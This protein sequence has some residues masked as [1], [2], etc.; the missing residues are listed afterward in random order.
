MVGGAPVSPRGY[1]ARA[2][3]T[4]WLRRFAMRAVGTFLGAISPVFAGVVAAL[5]LFGSSYSYEAGDSEG[6]S[7]SGTVTAFRYASEQGD[8]AWFFWAGF[9]VLVCLIAAAGALLGTSAI[10][11]ACAGALLVLSGLGMMTIGILVLPLAL[12]LFV[13]AVLLSAAGSEPAT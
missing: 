10:V 13:S 7:S 11:W 3:F 9:V 1:N 6:N 2:G 8:Y 5:M 4:G 12:L